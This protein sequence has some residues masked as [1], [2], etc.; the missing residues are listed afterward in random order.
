MRVENSP[1][2]QVN[3]G[4]TPSGRLTRAESAIGV[5]LRLSQQSLVSRMLLPISTMITARWKIVDEI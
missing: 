4:K 1:E 2:P 3:K 5:N